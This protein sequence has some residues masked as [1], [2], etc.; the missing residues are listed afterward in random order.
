MAL[1]YITQNGK[2]LGHL[3]RTRLICAHLRNYGL[4]PLVFA[5]GEDLE[6]YLP[7]DIVR[8]I[9]HF[10]KM[11]AD[12]QEWIAKEITG[13][14]RLSEPQVILEDTHPLDYQFPSDAQRALILRPTTYSH[15]LEVLSDSRL[16]LSRVFIADHPQSPTWPYSREQ[17]QQLAA[18][19]RV[20]AIGP[21]FSRPSADGIVEAAELVGKDPFC[22]VSAGGGGQFSGTSDIARFLERA[23]AVAEEI[24]RSRTMRFVL[25]KGPFF[26]S[27][28]PVPE[29]FTVIDETELMPAVF[30][31]ADGAILRP[32]FNSTWECIAALTPIYPIL[33]ETFEEPVEGRLAHIRAEGLLS[34]SPAN[35]WWN[36]AWRR[37]LKT[38][39][40]PL[41]ERWTGYPVGTEL[42]DFVRHAPQTPPPPPTKAKRRVLLVSINGVGMGHLARIVRLGKRLVAEGVDVHLAIESRITTPPQGLGFPTSLLADWPYASDSFADYL[43]Q[44]QALLDTFDPHC[45]VFDRHHVLPEGLA[46]IPQLA[47]REKIAIVS[48]PSPALL[49]ALLADREMDQ[50]FLLHSTKDFEELY[51]LQL[52]RLVEASDHVC[53]AG[54]PI[55]DQT[56]VVSNLRARIPAGEFILFVLGGGGEHEGIHD[57]ETIA[58]LVSDLAHYLRQE[59]EIE[60]VFIHGPYFPHRDLIP[61]GATTMYSIVAN[62]HDLIRK[63]RITIFRPGFNLSREVYGAAPA[64]IALDTYQSEEATKPHLRFL[65]ARKGGSVSS[66]QL[67]DLIARVESLLAKRPVTPEGT[68]WRNSAP[69]LARR[70]AAEDRGFWRRATTVFSRLAHKGCVLVRIDDVVGADPQ[71][72]WLLGALAER[73][74]P[75]SL[76]TIPFLDAT[77]PSW[78]EG[79]DPDASLFEISQHGFCHVNVQDVG[80]HYGEYAHPTS[81]R[82][83]E[84]LRRLYE[85]K[86]ILQD[87]HGRRFRG[88]FSPPFDNLPQWLPKAW[89][90]MGGRYLSM[91]MNVPASCTLPYVVLEADIWSWDDDRPR[92]LPAI[93]GDLYASITQ[94]GHGGLV[95]HPRIIPADV[96]PTLLALF[97]FL[98]EMNVPFGRISETAARPASLVAWGAA[99]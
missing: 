41:V 19:G 32:G 77:S 79:F 35:D 62:L 83:Q 9:P 64:Y 26:P 17:W 43:P 7:N 5:Q 69:A 2:G 42:A 63:A 28:V 29:L 20:T 89:Q 52:R 92:S 4:R 48:L 25:V 10:W 16:R 66:L 27:D 49:A 15:L 50:T 14:V 98:G 74:I 34:E 90:M 33:G 47:F 21:I 53:L 38:K 84:S 91:G 78:L 6:S 70:L 93:L 68:P 18:D 73:R 22:V 59:H 54:G 1:A 3:V 44:L 76:E 99:R 65:A 60:T 31:L 85:G 12:E 86:R 57:T 87:R 39:L 45:L 82:L 94:R 56:P 88:G 55:L 72:E 8:C 37:E 36:D 11:A 40:E 71:L 61:S 13:V 58:G 51:G 97:D 95:F 67:Q 80:E 81:A 96:R 30:A 23:A 46:A 24:L 75:A